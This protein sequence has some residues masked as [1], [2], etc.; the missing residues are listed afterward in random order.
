VIVVLNIFTFRIH[1]LGNTGHLWLY[2]EVGGHR[3]SMHLGGCFFT[4]ISTEWCVCSQSHSV[5]LQYISSL[6]CLHLFCLPHG[7]PNQS[8]SLIWSSLSLRDVKAGNIL[9]TE[10][11]QVKLGDFGSA[12]ISAPAN[13]FVGTPYWWD[14]PRRPPRDED[15]DSFSLIRFAPSYDAA[16]LAPPKM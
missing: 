8:L 13:S 9:L 14:S 15:V 3:T 10:P 11:G 6:M 7:F 16:K 1:W 2:V 12:S 5:R 4:S